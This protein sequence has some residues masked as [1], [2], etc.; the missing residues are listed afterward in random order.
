MDTAARQ[1]VWRASLLGSAVEMT[2]LLRTDGDQTVATLIAEGPAIVVLP[3]LP[4]A[5]VALGRLTRA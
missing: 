5:T 4:L 2:H 1:W 3:Y